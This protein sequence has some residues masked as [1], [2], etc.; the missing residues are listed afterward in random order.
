[1]K[2]MT[3]EIVSSEHLFNRP[4][5]TVRRDVVRLP[6][7]RINPEFYVLEY[8]DWVNVIAV[9]ED[10]QM[11]MIRQY[12]HGIRQTCFELC[13]GVAE[14][15]ETMEEAA[16]RELLEETGFGG[17]TFTE[18]MTISANAST[19]SNLTHCFLATGVRPIGDR[20]LDPTEDI[21]VHLLPQPEVLRMLSSGSFLQATMVA[22]LWKYFY[23]ESL[24]F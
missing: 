20:H 21:E 14:Q 13:A 9:T 6:D 18:I 1:M 16:R 12:R 8:P 4:W 2:D 7:G 19:T 23:D 10:R 17:G 15:G 5:L 11:V 22:P 24:P 3:W